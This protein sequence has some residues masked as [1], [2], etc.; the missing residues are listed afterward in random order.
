[1]SSSSPS[2]RRSRPQ[3]VPP[4]AA[5]PDF[6]CSHFTDLAEKLQQAAQALLAF[7]AKEQPEPAQRDTAAGREDRDRLVALSPKA[8]GPA[9]EVPHELRCY[10]V[11]S[12]MLKYEEET[13]AAHKA[14]DLSG[15]LDKVH[16]DLYVTAYLMEHF[17]DGEDIDGF[18]VQ[19][20]GDRLQTSVHVLSKVCSV[21]ADFR[22]AEAPLTA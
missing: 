7:A 9:G 21:L 3:F 1:M 17:N 20:I 6:S 5:S 2:A 16:D 10:R 22:P 19:L 4:D 8:A 14:E 18:T 11:P 15:L 13:L 12:Y